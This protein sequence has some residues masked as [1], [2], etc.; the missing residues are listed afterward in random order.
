MLVQLSIFKFSSGPSDNS[1]QRRKWH[2]LIVFLIACMLNSGQNSSFYLHLLNQTAIPKPMPFGW[3][4]SLFP[5]SPRASHFISIH[6][7]LIREAKLTALKIPNGE[8]P[9]LNIYQNLMKKITHFAKSAVGFFLQIKRVFLLF[10]NL[11]NPGDPATFQT[12][13]SN[14]EL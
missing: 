6:F 12:L 4:K 11:G 2:L 14:K 13:L 7:Q 1:G 8:S 5:P 3:E 9:S 10:N